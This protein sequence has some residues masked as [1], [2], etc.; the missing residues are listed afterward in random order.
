MPKLKSRGYSR[1]GI[2]GV[3]F[4]TGPGLGGFWLGITSLMP[5]SI[6]HRKIN[7]LDGGDES[8]A[9]MYMPQEV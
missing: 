7:A 8:T 3:E 6:L 4:R 5:P 9:S 1:F 2:L